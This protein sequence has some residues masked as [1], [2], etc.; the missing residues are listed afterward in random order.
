MGRVRQNPANNVQAAIMRDVRRGVF[1]V[2]DDPEGG[3][4]FVPVLTRTA[5]KAGWWSRLN[6]MQ[7]C[8]IRSNT[9][10]GMKRLKAM[11]REAG[12][13]H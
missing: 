6:R 7:P 13:D 5:I 12:L 3:I 10:L 2:P 1:V 8:I 9:K 4:D 11:A